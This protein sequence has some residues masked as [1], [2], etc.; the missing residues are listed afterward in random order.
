MSMNGRSFVERVEMEDSFV[1]ELVTCDGQ[2]G[3][4]YRVVLMPAG[5]VD[6]LRRALAF[7]A[8]ELA[9]YGE[10]LASGEGHAPPEGLIEELRGLITRK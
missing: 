9:D 1:L 10:V 8:V 5:R 2:D 6:D 3:P 7:K 4:C